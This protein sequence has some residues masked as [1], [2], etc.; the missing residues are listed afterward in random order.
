[1]YAVLGHIVGISGKEKDS[2]RM[3]RNGHSSCTM[4]E[5]RRTEDIKIHSTYFEKVAVAKLSIN[6]PSCPKFRIIWL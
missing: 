1:M 3:F 2:P 4:L 6:G 5:V